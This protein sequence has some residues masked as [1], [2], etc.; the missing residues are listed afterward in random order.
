MK[1]SLCTVAVLFA[2]AGSGCSG[3][4]TI[5]TNTVGDSRRT[6]GTVDPTPPPAPQPT[7]TGSRGLRTKP[8]T[9][10]ELPK[11]EDEWR[12]ILTREEF[13][14]LR[15]KDTE[16]RYMGYW[17]NKKSG[18][19]FCAGCGEFLFD[20]VSKFESDSGWPSFYQ[21]ATEKSVTA[22]TDTSVGM[23]RTEVHCKNC[24]GHLGHVFDDG[25]D[26]TGLR[27]CI[28]SVALKFEAKGKE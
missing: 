21:P 19:Y 10:E 28:N 17:N 4:D 20:S 6:P 7:P 1:T 26:P 8:M 11:T 3:S 27:Y 15:E 24:K 9:A 5:T 22:E 13:A 16:G 14:V 12:K 2:L 23:V 18:R 25:P